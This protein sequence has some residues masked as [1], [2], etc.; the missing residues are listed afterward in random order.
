M[1]RAPLLLVW[2]SQ[3]QGVYCLP[4]LFWQQTKASEF[5]TSQKWPPRDRSMQCLMGTTGSLS[6]ISSLNDSKIATSNCYIL[7]IQF[8]WISTV[9]IVRS[10]SLCLHLIYLS[11]SFP[12]SY[13]VLQLKGRGITWKWQ[14]SFIPL[15][16]L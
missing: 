12:W 13:F 14:C 16:H 4:V 5:S 6:Y 7:N 2:F 1:L 9:H 3:E 11:L 8:L 10:F 15:A